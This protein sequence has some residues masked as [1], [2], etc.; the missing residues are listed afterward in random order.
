[1]WNEIAEEARK[2][3]AYRI[4]I[5]ILRNIRHLY[6][7][8]HEGTDA[9]PIEFSAST[10]DRDPVLFRSS[11]YPSCNIPGHRSHPPRI[12]IGAHA[13]AAPSPIALHPNTVFTAITPST[14]RDSSFLPAPTNVVFQAT[15]ITDSSHPAPHVEVQNPRRPATSLR[16][17]TAVAIQG[18]AGPVGHAI[19]STA[20]SKF[21]PDPR[22][23]PA[24]S[25]PSPQPPVPSSYMRTVTPQCNA[26]LGV[27]TP[28][29]IPGVPHL[30]FPITVRSNTL[31]A[32]PQSN[33][34]SPDSRAQTGKVTPDPGFIPST[35]A[36]TISL[37]PRATSVSRPNVVM[38]GASPDVN[39]NS[40][41]PDLPNNVDDTHHPHPVSSVG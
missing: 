28:S 14:R 17:T 8:L 12:I 21:D 32:D 35:S 6:M 19:V 16:S 24:A 30:S 11:S 25:T 1:L 10:K 18:T 7:A 36:A 37:T 15:P 22:S 5:S 13:S 39:D 4:P 27:A 33:L 26:D 3:G 23:T 20:N 2:S 34:A 41:A 9:T 29:L 31:P 40:R 38:S